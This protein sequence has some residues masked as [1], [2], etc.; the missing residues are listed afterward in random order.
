[1]SA[2]QPSGGLWRHVLVTTDLSP[3]AEPALEAAAELAR[4]SA[5]RATVLNVLDFSTLGESAVLRETLVRLERE[6]RTH[7]TPR[8]EELAKRVFK[9]VP[10]QAAIVEGAGVAETVCRYAREHGV[11][12]I[13][14]A[15]H[16]RTGAR[17]MLIGSVTERVVQRAPCDVLVVRS[18]P[19][20]QGE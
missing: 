1:M 15:T 17:R 12:L 19:E 11:D 10:V 2:P 5:A 9:D 7:L 4:G 8:L 20:P 18:R 6:V 13:A 16:G 14:I 3:S